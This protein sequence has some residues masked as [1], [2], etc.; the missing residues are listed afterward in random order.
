MR[1]REFLKAGMAAA[2]GLPA[3][4]QLFTPANSPAAGIIDIAGRK[5]LFLDD[6]LIAEASRIS[7]FTGRVRKH[8]KN[9]LI[10]QDRPWEFGR[11]GSSGSGHVQSTQRANP[12]ITTGV[13]I[14]GQ[15]VLYDAEEK[16]FKLWYLPWAWENQLRPWCYAVSTD[17]I[18]WEKPDLGLYE[19]QGSRKNN[20]IGAWNDSID[21]G[22]YNVIKDPHDPDPGRRYKA[23]GELEG[24]AT[25]KGGCAVA[26]SSDG[27]RWQVQEGNPVVPKGPDIADAPTMLGWDPRISKYVYYPRPGHPIARE[28]SGNGSHRHIRTVG[29]SVSDD[30]VRWSPTRLMLAPDDKDRVDSQYMQFT[31]GIEGDVYVGFLMVHQTHEQTWDT[32]LLSSRDGFHWNWINRKVPFLGRG[33]VGAYDG[34]YMTPSG[35]IVHNGQIHVYYGAFTGS[36]SFVPDARGDTIMSIALATLPA[37]RYV[38]LLAGPDLATLV[39]RPITFRGTKLMVDLDASSPQ[40]QTADGTG[41]DECEVRAALVD[42]SGGAIDGFTTDRSTPLRRSGIQE[43]VWQ[44]VSA[45]RLENKPVRI[46]FEYR[47]AAIYSL[48]FA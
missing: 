42:Q 27:L 23:M 7:K 35:P 31:A 4:D 9:P 45:G 38:G 17:G 12:K 8:P 34:G 20:I 6:L 32:F 11:T 10:V 18:A 28:I 43:M 26:F 39:T 47:N 3:P 37:D 29:Y 48:Q 5:Q 33:E 2:A 13:E 46:R 15:T 14:T 1:R 25:V 30:F 40:Q 36:H 16:I 41:F 19:F 44:G 22:F 21:L 24:T